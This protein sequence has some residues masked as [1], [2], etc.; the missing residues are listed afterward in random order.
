MSDETDVIFEGPEDCF[1]RECWEYADDEG[2][3]KPEVERCSH[4][5]EVAPTATEESSSV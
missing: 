2:F 3:D 5:R 4:I 1:A